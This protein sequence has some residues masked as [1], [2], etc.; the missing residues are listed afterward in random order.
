MMKYN[1]TISNCQLN[2]GEQFLN[3]GLLRH[4]SFQMNS[5][6]F[7][8]V[9]RVVLGALMVLTFSGCNWLT[10]FDNLSIEA[11]EREGFYV[12]VLPTNIVNEM[13]LTRNIRMTSFDAHCSQDFADENTWNPITIN[14]TDNS[15]KHI[16]Y[17]SISPQD[18]LFDLTR[19]TST[20]SIEA[21]WILNREGEYYT[22]N[23]ENGIVMKVKDSNGLDVVIT[24]T[25]PLDQLV[26]LIESLEIVG[27]VHENELNAWEFACE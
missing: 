6:E 8:L 22:A 4:Q 19:E 27:Q 1:N 14:Y 12:Y 3:I 11:L 23:D 21:D 5:K 7:T 13:S 2:I 10:D 15:G 25:F 16:L 9:Y 24:S 20:V 26:R 17:V 18:A